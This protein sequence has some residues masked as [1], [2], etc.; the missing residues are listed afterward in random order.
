MCANLLHTRNLAQSQTN[1]HRD[2]QL[3]VTALK[4]LEITLEHAIRVT[5]VR[6]FPLC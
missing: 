3:S 1:A 2:T 4:S 6:A 5:E